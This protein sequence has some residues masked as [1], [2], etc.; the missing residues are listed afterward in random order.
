MKGTQNTSNGSNGQKLGWEDALSSAKAGSAG[1]GPMKVAMVGIGGYGQIY[2]SAIL[3]FGAAAGIELV[4]VADPFPSACRRYEDIV[5]R[6][7]PVFSSM[8]ALF[9]K[10]APELTVI[11]TPIQLHSAQIVQA[12]SHGSHVLCEKPLCATVEQARR[13]LDAE[14]KYKRHAAVGYQ[15]SYGAATQALKRDVIS[16]VLGRPIR[17]KTLTLWPRNEQYYS[18]NRWAGRLCD[19]QGQF[20]YDS[21]VNNACAHFLHN[22]LYVL[23]RSPERSAMPVEVQAELYRAKRIP[24]HDLGCVKATMEDGAEILFIATHACNASYG[25]VFEYE[26]ENAVVAYD[27]TAAGEFVARFHDGRV[28][29][30]GRPPEANSPDKLWQ[31]VTAIRS[32]TPSLCPLAAAVPQ[33]VVNC[34][35]QQAGE[36]VEVGE[37]YLCYSGEK[38]AR[39]IWVRG[40]D[41]GLMQCYREFKLPSEIGLEWAEPG[42]EVRISKDW[43]FKGQSDALA[44]AG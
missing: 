13:L 18:R 43:S 4:G 19:E 17:L 29:S 41:E 22:M 8:E 30:Y 26:F 38:G 35:A 34:A 2:A 1:R 16:G 15:W 14:V 33:I 21:P 39:E 28:K 42:G 36:I 3:D 40:A 20:V 25:P 44:A 5:G 23:G 37:E 7:V 9:S 32:G 10:V 27:E 12:M 11:S 6:G 31:T 24:N